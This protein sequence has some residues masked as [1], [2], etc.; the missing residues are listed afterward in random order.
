ML[1]GAPA[2]LGH[3]GERSLNEL[4]RIEAAAVRDAVVR[5]GGHAE[6]VGGTVCLSL[7][8]V[9]GTE[10]NRAIPTGGH[11][12]LDAV[13][14]WY[15]GRP[16]AVQV[17]PGHDELAAQLDAAG[18]TAGRAWMKFERGDAAAADAPTELAV[19]ETSDPAAFGRV[20]AEGS[21]IPSA[22]A[23]ALGGIVS[24]HGWHCFLAFAADGE[25][26][27]AGALFVDGTSGWLGAAATLP[28]FR[29][30]GAQSALLHAR[31]ETG[32]RLGVRTFATETG[33][34]VPGEPS[35]SYRNIQRFGFREAY[36]RPNLLW[37][38]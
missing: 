33:E 8:E 16:H 27:A 3:P 20:V 25:P 31:I 12:D 23:P 22:A 5:A 29:R 13:R 36:L 34:H 37:P 26:I 6:H 28:S 9:P 35:V 32:R 14:A 38:G 10:L 2:L 19:E 4:E 30:R 18:Y 11:V 7:P 24:V 1:A 17:P 15:G 21:G